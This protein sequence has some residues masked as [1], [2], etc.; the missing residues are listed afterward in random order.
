[1]SRSYSA[2]LPPAALPANTVRLTR[3]NGVVEL[4]FP[5]LRTPGVAAALG[6]FGLI[7]TALTAI[8]IAA[9]LPGTIAH[10]S[11]LIDAVLVAGFIVPFAFFGVAF[12]VL[13][14]YMACNALL[15]RIDREAIATWRILFGIAI[16]RSRMAW[17]EI[18]TIEPRI[19]ARHQSVFSSETIYELVALN[20]G[21][22]GRLVVAESLR[23]EAL[24]EQVRAL[25]D[26]AGNMSGKA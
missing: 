26:E 8:A 23:G 2:G 21:H 17:S 1:V 12:V 16:R 18:A 11:G 24:M 5:P 3:S 10:G 25:I 19:A 4:Y 7:A 13:A 9:L 6:A 15:V 20:E 14:M 22:T